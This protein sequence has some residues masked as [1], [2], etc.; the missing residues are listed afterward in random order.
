MRSHIYLTALL[1]A[2]T[3]AAGLAQ[4]QSFFDVKGT[5]PE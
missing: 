1:F 5:C 4:A 3:H 2:A